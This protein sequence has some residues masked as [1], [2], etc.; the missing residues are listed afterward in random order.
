MTEPAG[1]P[2]TVAQWLSHGRQR[3]NAGEARLLLARAVGRDA[4][5]IE[6]HR[7]EPL[8]AP[9]ATQYQSW[10][11]RRAEGEPIAYILGTREF[12]GRAFDVGPAVLIPR[13]ET[14]LLV[15]RVKAL[16]AGMASPALADLGTGSG[17]IAITLALEHP[18][19][20]VT[21]VERSAPA[22]A[23]A[24]AN[25]ERLGA[26]ITLEAG[27]WLEPLAGRRFDVIAA[28]PPYIAAADPHLLEGDVRREPPSALAS[29]PDGL[30]DLR[31]IITAAPGHL[32]PG[33]WLCLEHGYDQAA[34]LRSVLAAAG[35]VEIT[36]HADL[37]GILRVSCARF[38]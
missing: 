16:V 13:P 22:L 31:A 24:R 35:G 15:D 37:A 20:Q 11:Q 33:G 18:G 23:V 26:A 29:G 6:A 19:A 14:E 28:N 32:R 4:A 38:S 21:A 17:C 10:V 7:D 5:W 34:A 12:Y 1:S 25:A 2:V 36:Q 30:D 8:P 9:V 3:I 27:S